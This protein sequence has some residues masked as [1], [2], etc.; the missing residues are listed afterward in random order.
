MINPKKFYQRV[1]L[2]NDIIYEIFKVESNYRT[3]LNLLNLKLSQKIEDTKKKPKRHSKFDFLRQSNPLKETFKNLVHS[4]FKTLKS[5]DDIENEKDENKYTSNLMSESLKELLNFYKKK[6]N[7]IS[8]EVSNLGI[9]LYDFSSQKT[10]FEDKN[11]DDFNF[12]KNEKDFDMYC[13]ILIES[14]EKYFDKMNEIEL[15]LHN[16]DENNINNKLNN[17]IN[18]NNK[19]KNNNNIINEDEIEK[20]KIDELVECRK[21]YRKSLEDV[22]NS[23]RIYISKINE[24]C[25]EIQEFNIT[26]NN[27]LCKIFKTYNDHLLNLIKEVGNFCSLYENKQKKMQDLNM[28]FS[29]DL[30]FD[31]KLNM[32]YQFEEYN[33]KFNDMHNKKHLSVIQKMHKLIGFEYD[34]IN[35]NENN[36]INNN[37]DNNVLFIILMDK[38]L[39]G[40]KLN[41]KEKYLLKGLLSQQKYINEFLNK[42]NTIRINKKLFYNKEKFDILFEL[43]NTIYSKVSFDDEKNHEIVKLLMILSETFYY[44]NDDKKIFLNTVL[45]SPKEIKD[46]KFWIKYIEL[47]IEKENKKLS[48]SNNNTNNKIKK[49]S[50]FEYIV[51]L[52][53]I[54]H[55][56][57]NIGEKEKLK[58]IIEYFKDK[59]NFSVDDYDIIKSQ[60][61]I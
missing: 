50:K 53:N 43:F 58:Y 55:L 60:L 20:K 46:D 45:K 54:P 6:H 11:K 48:D 41:E 51:L 39:S 9:I 14:K 34:K 18:N 5:N 8:K 36:D 15:F 33:P 3:E 47:E 57:E 2:F 24:I 4:S 23:Q 26:E 27:M 17:S 21:I 12:E 1:K 13:N 49:K 10:N 52:S 37:K 22:N 28:E 16:N 35:K 7:I 59:Y 30:L 31:A 61:N 38:F 56:R 44:K 42:L 29:N 40:E 19:N 32:N 25:N